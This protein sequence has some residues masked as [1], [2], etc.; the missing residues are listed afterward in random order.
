MEKTEEMLD[1]LCISIITV[2]V[3]AFVLQES[4]DETGDDGKKKKRAI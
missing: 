3:C 1:K 4:K 2:H